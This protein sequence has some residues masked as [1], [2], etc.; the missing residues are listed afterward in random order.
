MWAGVANLGLIVPLFRH[1]VVTYYLHAIIMWVLAIFT[2]AGSFLQLIAESGSLPNGDL[3]ET[4]GIIT[5]ACTLVICVLGV[6]MRVSQESSNIP[7]WVVHYSRYVHAIGGIIVWLVA[8]VALLLAWHGINETVF[9]ALLV[10]QVIFI[11]LRTAYRF[12]PPRI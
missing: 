2:F 11:I 8:Q 1:T 7:G 3:H 4:F 9:I 10:W 6:W 5:M 12:F